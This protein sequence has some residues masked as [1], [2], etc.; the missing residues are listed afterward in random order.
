MKPQ[1]HVKFIPENIPTAEA[2]IKDL[3]ETRRQVQ[4][5]LE[6]QQKH[7]Q[8]RRLTEMKVGDWVL[9]EATNLNIRGSRK[10]LSRRY[11]PYQITERIG[12]VAY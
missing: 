3:E 6:A 7:K 5:L 10:L 12:P 8:N 4:N 11:G 2:H 1:V 9:L